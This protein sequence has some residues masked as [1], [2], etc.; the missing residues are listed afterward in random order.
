MLSKLY[1]L[2]Y[3]AA[4]ADER[5]DELMRD[6]SMTLVDIRY[7]PA[8]R[9]RP[10][11]RKSALEQRFDVRY[12]HVPELGNVNYRDST[13]PI[14]LADTAAGLSCVLFWLERG[15]SVCLLCACAD[16]RACH[17]SVVARL[18][19]ERCSCEVVHC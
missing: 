13:L 2:G 8:S 12:C 14:V 19:Q 9:Y 10:Q 16:A 3:A 15:Y 5:L 6:A 1:T 11:Y 18:V 4:G 7:H 17:R